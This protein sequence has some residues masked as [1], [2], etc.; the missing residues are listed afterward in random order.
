MTVVFCDQQIDVNIAV[1]AM[2]R[3]LLAEPVFKASDCL[4]HQTIDD[5]SEFDWQWA[6]IEMDRLI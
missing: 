4:G 5:P 6:F 1:T 2:F 3:D